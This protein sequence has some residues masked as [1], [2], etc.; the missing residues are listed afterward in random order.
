[1]KIL[2]KWV[3]TVSDGRNTI[4]RSDTSETSRSK[5][6]T[7]LK[8]IR[9]L[10][11]YVW[12]YV[13]E[14]TAGMDTEDQIRIAYISILTFLKYRMSGRFSKSR[15]KVVIFLRKSLDD[16]MKDSAFRKKYKKKFEIYSNW[17]KRISRMNFRSEV[18]SREHRQIEVMIWSTRLSPK[19][20]VIWRL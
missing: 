12:P 19:Y 6:E 16:L 1:M 8:L 18:T 5:E 4:S 17:K 15:K 10:S 20:Q 2:K 7:N 11:T 13:S 9:D 3:E 14:S